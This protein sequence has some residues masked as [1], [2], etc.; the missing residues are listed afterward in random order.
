MTN[1]KKKATSRAKKTGPLRYA[2]PFFTTT[3][4][5]QRKSVPGVGKGLAEF[6]LGRLL[7]IPPVRANSVLQLADIIGEDGVKD[8]ETAGKII[9][10]SFGDSGHPDSN[11]QEEIAEVMTAAYQPQDPA[12]SPSFLLHLGDVIYYDNTVQGY[13]EQFYVPYKK[14]PGKIIAIPGNHDGEL[15][16][17]DL[18]IG[19]PTGQKKTLEAFQRNFCQAKTGV[20]PDAQTI[21]RQMVAQ[22]GV[23]WYLDT[24]FVDI[25][26]LYSNVG[27]SQGAI[28]GSEIGQVQKKW[29]NKTLAGIRSARTKGTRKALLIAVHHPP[30]SAGGHSPS[31]AMFKDIQDS[32]TTSQILPDAILSG[33]SHSYQR[34]TW[35]SSLN[36]QSWEVPV[37]VVGTGGRQVTHVK[38]ATGART[39]DY[40]FESS[41]QG[42]GFLTVEA[43]A[44]TISFA[45][46]EVILNATGAPTG[47]SF[48]QKVT[49][50]LN[51]HKT[52]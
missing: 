20:P 33:H 10:H 50:D 5:D 24:P 52:R 12:G 44:T 13:Q 27:E 29:L 25:I 30:L 28:S 34:F 21:Y 4:P 42:Y 3:P 45:F 43:T 9:F 32:F 36:G 47:K 39:G 40:S 31:V 6:S 1:P 35:Y 17:Y 41:L 18:P 37:F 22:P 48:D 11:N 15:F 23:Y 14:Y 8:V 16:K 26:G 38:A 19:K 46:T 49:V 7:P 51:T 2:H